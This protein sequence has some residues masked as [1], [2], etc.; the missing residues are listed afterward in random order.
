MLLKD[1]SFPHNLLWHFHLIKIQIIHM[2]GCGSIALPVSL[3]WVPYHHITL[4]NILRFLFLFSKWL[5]HWGARSNKRGPT[6]RETER[7]RDGWRSCIQQECREVTLLLY[8]LS[9]HTSLTW[10]LCGFGQVNSP[11]CVVISLNIK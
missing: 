3:L 7:A 6:L 2:A 4:K 10:Y 1:S 8:G 11:F 9:Y 5:P